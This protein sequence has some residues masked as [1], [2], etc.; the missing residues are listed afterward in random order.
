MNYKPKNTLKAWASGC[1]LQKGL[2]HWVARRIE[3]LENNPDHKWEPLAVKWAK[4]D[5]APHKPCPNCGN[6]IYYGSDVIDIICWHCCYVECDCGNEHHILA[7][8]EK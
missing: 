5:N 4:E 8:V 1:E 6:K 3:K 7:E 2:S